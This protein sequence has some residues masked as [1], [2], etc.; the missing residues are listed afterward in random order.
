MPAGQASQRLGHLTRQHGAATAATQAEMQKQECDKHLLH[1]PHSPSCLRISPG[2][3]A[4]VPSGEAGRVGPS[5]QRELAGRQ[6]DLRGRAGQC[7]KQTELP[8]PAARGAGGKARRRGRGRRWTWQGTGDA[9]SQ[10]TPR[11]AFEEHQR[12][13]HKTLLRASKV[14]IGQFVWSK[15]RWKPLAGGGG[16]LAV[17]S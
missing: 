4:P 3:V 17:V 7:G 14:F 15:F 13:L 11:R 2:S 1:P 9:W 10:F 16:G 8:R 5:S 12:G 6:P